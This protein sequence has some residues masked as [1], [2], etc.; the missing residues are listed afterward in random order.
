MCLSTVCYNTFGWVLTASQLANIRMLKLIVQG[1][2]RW[3]VGGREG[4]R[5]RWRGG[6]IKYELLC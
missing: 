6:G 2:E 4:G 1:E 5:Q 3:M